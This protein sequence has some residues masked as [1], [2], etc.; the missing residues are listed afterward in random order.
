MQLICFGT[1]ILSLS[2]IPIGFD[3]GMA[4]LAACDAACMAWPW[5]LSLGISIVF[6]AL[7]TKTD[8]ILRVLKAASSFSRVQVTPKDVIKPLLGMMFLNVVILSIWTAVAPMKWQ[9]SVIEED[10]FGRP[11]ETVGY[12][13]SSETAGGSFSSYTDV[14]FVVLLGV[15]N[16]GA[17]GLALWSA[18]RAQKISVEFAETKYIFRALGLMSVIAFT[19]L[20]SL[21]IARDKNYAAFVFLYASVVISMVLSVQ[22]FIFVPKIQRARHNARMTRLSQAAPGG[23]A[24]TIGIKIEADGRTRDSLLEEIQELRNQIADT[25]KR[26]AGGSFGNNMSTTQ[27]KYSTATNSTRMSNTS[28]ALSASL[29]ASVAETPDE[30]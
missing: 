18:S 23:R 16:L 20:P 1:F 4:S 14:I 12:C 25:R 22:L 17:I 24:S 9:T 13:S 7:F 29:I 8:R 15:V 6:G 27:N 28:S 3:P 11:T 10:F 19:G 26:A 2:I 21:I 30:K 5:L